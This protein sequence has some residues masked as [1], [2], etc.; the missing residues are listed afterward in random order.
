MKK[1]KLQEWAF[2][3]ETTHLNQQGSERTLILHTPSMSI[4]EIFDDM[5]IEFTDAQYK[6]DFDIYTG[7]IMTAVI[8]KS[9]LSDETELNN[10]LEEVAKFYNGY[11]YWEDG[12]IIDTDTASLN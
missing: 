8:W 2:L 9:D 3:D 11:A 7:E 6:I 5:D 4:I 10:L 1:L 12:N